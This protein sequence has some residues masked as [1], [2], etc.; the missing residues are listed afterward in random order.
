MFV[1]DFLDC[2]L[3]VVWW[4]NDF[5]CVQNGFVNKGGDCVC[6][7]VVNQCFQFGYVMGDKLFFGL[8]D[9]CVVE[10]VGCFGVDD[11]GEW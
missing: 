4:G 8:R 3:I 9:I 11:L 7:F 6:F 5:I 1:Q 2:F 10:V